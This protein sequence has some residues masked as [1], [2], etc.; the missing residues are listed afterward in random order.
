MRRCVLGLL[1]VV[2]GGAFLAGCATVGSQGTE[3]DVA[4]IRQIWTSYVSAV[5]KGDAAAWLALWD[6]NGIQLRP[7]APQRSR[8]EL[9]AQVPAAFKA[10]ADAND[11]TMV[12]NPQEITVAGPWAYSRG[13]FTQDLKNRTTGVVTHVDGKFMTIFKR[14]ADGTWRIYRD[15]Y[16][17]NVATK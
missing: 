11:V 1:V 9:D 4:A 6:S 16:N 7:D 14:Q 10:R 15:C 17:S 3:A 12:I 8:Q 2:A 5:Q 13:Q